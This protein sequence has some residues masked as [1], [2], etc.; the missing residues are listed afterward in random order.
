V[1][2]QVLPFQSR[3][4][5]VAGHRM[6]YL[7][8]GSGPTVLL[9]HGNPTWCFFYRNVIRELK[10]SFR[11]IAP[12]FLGCGLSDRTPGVQF[13]AI[14]RIN[15]LEEFVTALGITNFS[16]VMHDWGGPLGTGFIQRRLDSVNRIVY[17]NTTLTET[18]ALPGFIK[19]AAS[20]VIGKFMTRHTD[21][22]VRMTTSVGAHKKLTPE[23]V[24][25]YRAPY[26]S[27][28]RRDAIWDF[29]ADIPFGPEHPTY[30]EM[31]RIAAN[32][33]QVAQKPVKIIW[34]LKDPCFHRE[35]LS[36]VAAHFPRA[37]LLEIPDASHLV[38]DDAP[39]LAIPAIKEFLSRTSEQLEVPSSATEC[40]REQGRIHVMYD[41]VM[42][43]AQEMPTASAVVVPRWVRDP[44]NGSALHYSHTTYGD[45]AKLV[46]QYQRGLSELGLVPGD[47]VLMLVTPGTDFLALGLA[48][49]GRGATPVFVDPGIGIEKLSRCIQDAAP[50]AFIGSPRAHLLR[51]LKRSLFHRIKFHVTASE[52]A[53]TGGYSLGFFKR[54]ANVPLKPVPL[55]V[56]VNGVGAPMKAADAAL[57]AFTSGATGTPKG[58]IFTNGML[59][60]QLGIIRD[61][62]GQEA[63]TRDLTL[64]PIFS[65]YNAALGVASVFPVMPAGKPLSLDAA[66]VVKLVGDLA[67]QSSF[68]SPTLWHKIAEYTLR[69][70]SVLPTLKRVFMAGAAVPVATLELVKKAIPNGEAS[71]PYGATEALPV[72]FI[73][74]TDLRSGQ[75]ERAATGEQGTPVGKVV[76]GIELRVVKSRDDAF[77]TIEETE[78]LSVGE[79]GEIIVRGATVSPEY[80][81]RVDANKVGKIRDGQTFWHRMGDLG[82]VDSQGNLYYCG[83]K[84]HSIYTPEKAFHSVPI[85]EI[86]NHLPQVRRSALVAVRGGREPAIVIEP[87]PQ[88]FPETEAAISQFTAKLRECAA[89]DSLSEEITKFFFHKSFPVDARHNAKIY[90]DQLGEWADKML[91][92]RRAA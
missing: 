14:D 42:R 71:T 86:F 29:V 17:L 16:I 7:D 19:L 32:L 38:L 64:L 45:L 85:E 41:Q 12:D 9:L 54:F 23:V 21:T 87:Y 5:T 68:G 58:V 34:G 60:H 83:R 77:T 3:F 81:H 89:G 67:I 82:Y 22:F 40:E 79:I 6:H 43:W 55:P 56:L 48:V 4:V 84:A 37:E 35:M 51:L 39:Q 72:T 44:I 76:P 27:R 10:D 69:S 28:R 49:M 70:G 33:P 63:G 90:R 8:E 36:K 30:T 18:E 13:R 11:L 24:D 61:V 80:L 53:F 25:G 88:F 46:N 75:W 91:S 1:L 73:T 74:A 92:L 66:Q 59:A 52:W 15:Q 62:L 78:L 20:P 31:V 57:I 50:H 65:L 26:R 2:D 47:R